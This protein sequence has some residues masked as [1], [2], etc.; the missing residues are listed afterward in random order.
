MLSLRFYSAM[1]LSLNVAA[2]LGGPPHV[3]IHMILPIRAM[4]CTLRG[5]L[6][7]FYLYLN[8]KKI[9]CMC[10]SFHILLAVLAMF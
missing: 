7:P 1:N 8:R 3:T 2:V 9:L 10:S 6:Q 5:N 4:V